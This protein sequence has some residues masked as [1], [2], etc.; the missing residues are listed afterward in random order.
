MKPHISKLGDLLRESGGGL[1]L[2]AIVAA[3]W[4][5]GSTRHASIVIL[6]G[7][8]SAT[9]LCWGAGCVFHHRKPELSR[10]AI[11]PCFFLFMAGW[12]VVLAGPILPPDPFTEDHVRVLI[13]RW[14]GSFVL[15]T[16]PETMWLFTGL[17]GALLV[18]MDL[19]SNRRWW[20]AIYTT[21]ALTGT[22]IVL[23]GLF[24][25]QTGARGILWQTDVPGTGHF[26]GTFFHHSLAG[27]FINLVWPL[28]A[29]RLLVHLRE[30]VPSIKRSSGMIGWSVVLLV[31]LCGPL[32]QVSRFAQAN[33]L[34]LLAGVVGMWLRQRN[35]YRG[36]L[37]AI[38]PLGF[39][40]MFA[41]VVTACAFWLGRLPD[42]RSRWAMFPTGR[43]HDPPQSTE[44][45]RMRP[46]E[47]IADTEP[48]GFFGA[49]KIAMQTCLRMI[50]QAGLLGFGPGSWATTYPHFTDDPMLRTF[51]L[52][53]Q[54][55][56]V[57]WLQTVVEWGILGALAWGVLIVGGFRRGF[58]WLRT[59]ETGEVAQGL[60]KPMVAGLL[61]ALCGL[62]LHGLIDFPLQIPSIQL[63]FIVMLGLAWKSALTMQYPHKRHSNRIL[64]HYEAIPVPADPFLDPTHPR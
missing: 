34:I 33:A 29:G 24:Q 23:L 9:V 5:Y 47:F 60:Q 3:P 8:L 14:P 53:V 40:L 61:L 1:L 31:G 55:A 15:K 45:F 25:I 12:L 19:S 58:R 50:P 4:M 56:H 62:L 46:D 21:M 2:V 10:W 38:R 28:S 43:S 6:C 7:L 63:Y 11:Y 20:S 30:P 52:H 44:S 36:S 64:R 37:S 57:D 18:T 26:F 48:G 17:L 13:R 22:S 39:V 27:A 42:I 54:F 41:V 59:H 32:A 49:R 51:F 35:K 16:P